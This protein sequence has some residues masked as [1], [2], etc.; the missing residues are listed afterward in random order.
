M[1]LAKQIDLLSDAASPSNLSRLSRALESSGYMQHV[2][3][4]LLQRQ[5]DEDRNNQ[6][7]LV[8]A[9]GCLALKDRTVFLT[10]ADIT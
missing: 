7:S 3:R 1:S 8:K 2:I 10:I 5:G 9:H 4:S 6:P